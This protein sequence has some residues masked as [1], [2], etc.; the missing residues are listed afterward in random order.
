VIIETARR[1]REARDV[2]SDEANALH[3]EA[4]SRFKAR[5]FWNSNPPK[6]ENGLAVIHD[7]LQTYGDMD[8]WRLAARIHKVMRRHAS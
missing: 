4:L 8:A 5:C 1:L 7:R 2:L 6:S 3:E